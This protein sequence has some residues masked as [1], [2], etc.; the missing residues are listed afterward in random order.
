MLKTTVVN[1]YRDEYD[2][3]IGRPG[4]GETGY[5]GNPFLG[6][7]RTKSITQFKEYFYKRLKT[8]PEFARKVSQLSGKRLGCFCRPTKPCHGDVIAEYLNSLS[9]TPIKIAVIGS[10]SFSDY[11]FMCSI[12]DHYD[13][14]KIISGGA[15]GADTLG[16][17]Y[18]NDNGIDIQEFLPDWE[19]LG[20]KAGMIRNRDIIDACNEVIAFWN[21]ESKGTK[22]AI[23][24]A[25]EKGKPVHIYWP[26]SDDPIADWFV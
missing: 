17:M 4:K 22:H 15:R 7:N 25:E 11:K 8:D 10:R 16:K 20:K 26:Q 24:H 18:A 2:V 6:D 12:L 23:G 14:K 1:I 19:K 9:G 13:I 5:F 3:Y 21:G